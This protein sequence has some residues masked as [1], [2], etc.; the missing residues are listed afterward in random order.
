MR[1]ASERGGSRRKLWAVVLLI[2]LVAALI[3]FLPDFC[4]G[5]YDGWMH[6]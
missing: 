4:R 3:A 6:G 2:A 1:D 5:F